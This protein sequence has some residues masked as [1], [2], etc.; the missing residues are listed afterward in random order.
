MKA[1]SSIATC[2]DATMDG[3]DAMAGEDYAEG[4]GIVPKEDKVPAAVSEEED[5][6]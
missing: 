5:G 3:V 1:L 6:L 4:A 2:M